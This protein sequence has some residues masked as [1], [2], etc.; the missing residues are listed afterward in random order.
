MPVYNYL[1]DIHGIEAELRDR[2][3]NKWISESDTVMYAII[4]WATYQYVGEM[5]YE[6]AFFELLDNLAGVIYPDEDVVE[7]LGMSQIRQLET[8]CNDLAETVLDVCRLLEPRIAPYLNF[9]VDGEGV[10]FDIKFSPNL[11]HIH[12]E[13]P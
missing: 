12:I 7:L 4:T 6:T 2:A 1:I 3:A 5:C 13:A 9:M 8:D 10:V 11:M